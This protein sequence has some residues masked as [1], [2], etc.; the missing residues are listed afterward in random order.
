MNVSPRE[1][2]NEDM[3]AFGIFAT[4]VPVVPSEE[5]KEVANALQQASKKRKASGDDFR[6]KW[7]DISKNP[8]SEYNTNTKIFACAFPW[9]FPSGEGDFL[10]FREEK[11]S[12]GDWARNLIMYEDSHFVKDKMFSFFVLNY[13]TR[14]RNQSSGNFFVKKFSQNGN[15]DIRS[16]QKSVRKGDMKFVNEIMYFAKQVLGSDAYWRHKRN[17][18]YSWINH[19]VEM[20][21]GPPSYFL[22]L[23][24]TEY[25]WPDILRLVEE[26]IKI[27]TG[28]CHQLVCNCSNIVQVMNNYSSVVQEYFQRRTELWLETVGRDV[29]GIAH[30][31]MRYEFAPSRG[32]IHA[33]ILAISNDKQILYDMYKS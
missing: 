33:H 29:F 17:E 13:V 14:R 10:D 9:L 27:E 28:K 18:L 26:R 22:T 32:Q 20:E 5:D 25:Y 30:Y 11:I 6:L 31:W 12:V 4:N 24:C 2:S 15:D 7:P 23:S 3:P 8:I 1:Q 19:H 21:N 16:L